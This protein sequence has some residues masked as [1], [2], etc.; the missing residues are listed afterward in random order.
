MPC[1]D[2][3][4]NTRR[5]H[6]ARR[7][8]PSPRPRP[9]TGASSRRTRR[10]VSA[11]CRLSSLLR[12]VP[13]DISALQE[14]DYSVAGKI[15]GKDVLVVSWYYDDTAPNKGV[16]LAI[17]DAASKAYRLVLLVEPYMNGATPDFRS[18]TRSRPCR[19]P[20]SCTA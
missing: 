15:A 12:S 2:T 10:E 7:P 20:P 13:A 14:L 8:S 11:H 17:V 9:H 5:K 18:I 16:R 1:R 6:P 19:P 4:R 3:T